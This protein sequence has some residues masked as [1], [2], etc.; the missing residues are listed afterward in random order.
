MGLLLD[1]FKGVVMRQAQFQMPLVDGDGFP[2]VN[3][4][5]LAGWTIRKGSD[6]YLRGYRRIGG[7]VRCVYLGK[8]LIGAHDKI[9]A[10]V[11]RLGDRDNGR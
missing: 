11:A 9:E 4:R 10:K 1:I 6:G 2:I 3:G 5:N 8:N 7:K